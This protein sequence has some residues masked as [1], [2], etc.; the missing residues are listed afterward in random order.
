L[1]L[2]YRLLGVRVVFDHHD[3]FPEL[4]SHHYPGL[5]GRLLY[6]VARLMEFLTFRTAHVTMSTNESYRRVARDRG[7]VPADRVLVLRNGPRVKEFKPVEPVPALKQGF[8][9][10]VCYAGVMGQQDG[11]FELLAS[12]RYVVHELRRRDI[13]FVLLGDGA[14]RSE[15]LAKVSE[16]N[17]DASVDMP[18]M[19]KDKELLRQ[20]L[21]TADVCV[22]PEPLTPL[23]NRSTFIKIGEYMAMGKPVVAYNLDETRHTAQ[24]AA[25]YAEPGNI[26]AFGEA[27]VAVLD[28]TELGHRMGE[29]GRQR[30]LEHLSWEH[31]QQNL[32]RAYA[33]ALGQE[34]ALPSGIELRRHDIKDSPRQS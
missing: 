21:C 22:S 27:I 28:D 23:N 5:G 20:Y 12:I 29:L 15:A 32:F 17:L 2:F 4:I 19:I 30:I 14:V 1:A 7:R 9:H 18:G 13:L 16:W 25:L 26:E 31:Q 11:V 6:A 34:D 3:L 8:D 33:L 24:E 10:M